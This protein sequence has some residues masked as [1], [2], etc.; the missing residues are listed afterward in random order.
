MGTRISSKLDWQRYY[1]KTTAYQR[2]GDIGYKP[3]KL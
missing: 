1:E 3:Q 2:V